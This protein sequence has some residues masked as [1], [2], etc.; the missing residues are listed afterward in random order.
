MSGKSDFFIVSEEI[1]YPFFNFLSDILWDR[2]Y[3]NFVPKFGQ[4]LV[5]N[6]LFTSQRE[7]YSVP[8]MNFFV[9]LSLILSQLELSKEE[10]T[11]LT[12]VFDGQF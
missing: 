10:L 1:V 2:I 7:S 4:E 11:K 9:K 12:Q 8:N 5:Y 6:Y 3:L